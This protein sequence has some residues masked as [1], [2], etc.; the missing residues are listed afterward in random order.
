MEIV[1]PTALKWTLGATILVYVAAMYAIAF[2]A[3][4]RIVTAEDYIV[5]G[6]RLPFSLA[7]MT[8]LGT[9]FGAETILTTPDEVRVRGLVATAL[10]PLGVG[11]CLVVAGLFVAAPMWRMQL[12]TLPEFFGRKF[13]RTA[14]LLSALIMVPSYFGWIAAQYVALAGILE[15][16]FGLDMRIGIAVVAIVGGGYTIMGGMWSVAF[17]DALQISLVLVGIVI[18]G[19]VVLYQLGAGDFVAGFERLHTDVPPEKL[20][21]IPAED[22]EALV[23]WLAVLAIGALGNLPGQDL[24]QRIFASKSARVAQGACLFAGVAYLSFGM[25]PVGLGLAS[26]VIAPGAEGSVLPI[27]AGAFLTP[28]LAVV[29]LVA[30]LSAVLSTID[31][32]IIAPSSVLAQN[33]LRPVFP[34][35][36]LALNRWST[37]VVGAGSL[38]MAYVG[39][40]AYE[41][42]ESAYAATL[43]GLFVPMMFG[44][45]TRPQSGK[46]ALASIVLGTGVWLVH[47]VCGWE[48][49]LEFFPRLGAWRAP[50]SLAATAC[51]LLAY[52]VFEPPW[53]LRFARSDR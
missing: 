6:R 24:L 30:V 3:R 37:V 42:L 23:G 21:W 4:K 17:T 15:L 28:V 38:V 18:L 51:S 19:G 53:R 25:I 8:L 50:I 52:L 10:D 12:L 48:Y 39:E 43:V 9:W 36:L 20:D 31:S 14:E 34:N 27:L 29:F 40:S 13:G 49:F 32:A 33:V 1:V 16:Y 2:F 46:A 22:L 5:A 7:W 35:H 45:Y 47:L 26:S 41:L 44:L 11:L